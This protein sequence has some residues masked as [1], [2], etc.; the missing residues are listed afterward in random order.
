MKNLWKLLV[1]LSVLGAGFNVAQAAQT[2]QKTDF[3]CYE[4]GPS[5]NLST[6]ARLDANGNMI[7]L[8]NAT[9][10]G[11]V[12]T[13]AD[14]IQGTVGSGAIITNTAPNSSLAIPVVVSSGVSQ[15]GVLIAGS[16]TTA[17]PSSV[18][19]IPCT[20]SGATTVIGVADVAGSSGTVVNVDYSGVGVVLTT[21]TV[22]VGDLLVSSAPAT[23]GCIAATNNSASVGT[24]IG[25]ALTVGTS[26]SSPVLTRVLL[27][28]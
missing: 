13:P 19:G 4:S 28:H 22:S 12:A 14:I 15:G 8:G 7:L 26:A 2:C 10:A 17:N 27:H 25:T 5:Q 24:V 9:V 11:T 6:P 16:T 3:F 1:A 21:G 23:G 20:T 18:A